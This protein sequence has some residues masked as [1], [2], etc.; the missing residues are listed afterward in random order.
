MSKILFILS[1]ILWLINLILFK[2]IE[3]NIFNYIFVAVL[4]IYLIYIFIRKKISGK[5]SQIFSC[6]AY[7]Y[8]FIAALIIFFIAILLFINIPK[9]TVFEE[10]LFLNKTTDIS[11]ENFYLIYA[12]INEFSNKYSEFLSCH[13]NDIKNHLYNEEI[14]KILFLTQTDRNDI[15]DFLLKNKISIPDKEIKP[16]GIIPQYILILTIINLEIIDIKHTNLTIS[17]KII[18]DKY[19]NLWLMLDSMLDN[20]SS[21]IEYL[22][23]LDGM[24]ILQD[25]FVID[26]IENLDNNNTLLEIIKRIEKKIDKN[27]FFLSYEYFAFKNAFNIFH[28]DMKNSKNINKISNNKYIVA[29]LKNGWPLYDYYKT[30][31]IIHTLFYKIKMMLNKPYYLQIDDIKSYQDYIDNNFIF[32]NQININLFENLIGKLFLECMEPSKNKLLTIILKKEICKSKLNITKYI[33][34]TN[35]FVI[36]LDIPVDNLTGK[37]YFF[38]E[39]ETNYFL[40]SDFIND[41]IKSEINYEIKKNKK[42]FR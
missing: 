17:K 4:I 7:V 6:L 40:K 28:N 29:I 8:I 24:N 18:Q 11:K 30:L 21:I 16:S 32:F 36:K 33:I 5:I 9:N 37:K 19:L 35:K 34:E 31:K 27:S 14:K 38:E 23:I 39:T 25:Y 2:D 26:G 22:V 20:C 3:Q 1:I 42:N 10:K 41:N 12:K 15:I 13:S